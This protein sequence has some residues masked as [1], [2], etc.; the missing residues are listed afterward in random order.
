[1]STSCH[2]CSSI[3]L[4]CN[5]FQKSKGRSLEVFFVFAFVFR[6]K[7]IYFFETISDQTR[8]FFFLMLAYIKMIKGE[9][10]W[11]NIYCAFSKN[12]FK[13]TSGNKIIN[14]E[15]SVSFWLLIKDWFFFLFDD[16]I[17]FKFIKIMRLSF[18]LSIH[19]IWEIL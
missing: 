10:M 6:K 4:D 7:L 19:T 8:V 18:S 13:I 2:D 16:F 12:I 1:M 15:K 14:L 5:W 17:P 11:L 3:F 9:Y